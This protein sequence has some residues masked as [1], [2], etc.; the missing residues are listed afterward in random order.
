MNHRRTSDRVQIHPQRRGITR[1]AQARLDNLALATQ[2]DISA[3]VAQTLQV[4]T[5]TAASAAS[6]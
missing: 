6:T 3:N 1:R 4:L 2:F 5:Q